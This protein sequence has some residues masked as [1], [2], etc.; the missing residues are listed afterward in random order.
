[1]PIDSEVIEKQALGSTLIEICGG[2]LEERIDGKF[3]LKLLQL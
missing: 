3:Q 1:M 2:L